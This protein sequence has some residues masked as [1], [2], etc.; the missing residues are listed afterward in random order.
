[1]PRHTAVRR[2]Y[3]G[4]LRAGWYGQLHAAHQRSYGKRGAGRRVVSAITAA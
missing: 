4:F 2:G 3:V 1:M